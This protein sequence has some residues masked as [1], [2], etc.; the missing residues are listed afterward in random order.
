[1]IKKTFPLNFLNFLSNNFKIVG[2]YEQNKS[3]YELIYVNRDFSASFR[4]L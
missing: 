2:N 3:L 1:M 4:E